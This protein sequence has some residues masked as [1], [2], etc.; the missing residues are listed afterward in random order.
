MGG[1][2]SKAVN[3][4]KTTIDAA[5]NTTLSSTVNA[6][7]N[8]TCSNIQRVEGVECCVINFGDQTCEATAINEVVSSGR[9]DSTVTQGIAQQIAQSAQASVEGLLLGYAESEV[10]NRVKNYVDIAVNTTQTFET[11]CSKNATGLN[12]QTVID[13]YCGCGAE[14]PENRG[15]DVNFGIQS[16]TL[17]AMGSCVSDVV[18]SSQAAQDYSALIG[19]TAEASVSGVSLLELFLAI[20]GP[21]LI[22]IIAP[23]GFKILTAPQKQNPTPAQALQQ[24]GARVRNTAF[25]F[26]LFALI[27]WYPGIVAWQLGAPPFQSNRTPI[28]D[29][30]AC[31]PDGTARE[32]FTINR[33]QWFDPDCVSKPA[34]S[35]CSEDDQYKSYT[36]CGVFGKANLC[37]DTEFETDRNLFDQMLAACSK[38]TN[39]YQNRVPFGDVPTIASR[40]LREEDKWPSSCRICF[41][42]EEGVK[43]VN[44]L[45]VQMDPV[46]LGSEDFPECKYDQPNPP[47]SC[48]LPCTGVD[49]KAYMAAGTDANGDP[50]LCE[51]T[52]SEHCY[53]SEAAYLNVSPSECLLPAYQQGKK[54]ISKK[55][56]EVEAAEDIYR[57]KFATPE[58]PLLGKLRIGDMCSL[59]PF[60]WLNCNGDFS[61]NYETQLPESD[62]NFV[63]ADRACRN[64]FTDCQDAQFLADKAGQDAVDDKCADD[65]QTQKERDEFL[66]SIPMWSGVAYFIFFLISVGAS[67]WGSRKAAEV[68]QQPGGGELMPEPIKKLSYATRAHVVAGS[69][70]T[71][72]YVLPGILLLGLIAGVLG[73]VLIE[74]SALTI[75]ITAGCGVLLLVSLAYGVYAR[76]VARENEK[77]VRAFQGDQQ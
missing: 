71:F 28:V 67:L 34:G 58:E 74:P 3:N 63:F 5:V 61:C 42:N 6:S 54:K 55:L 1:G 66:D 16:I 64:D 44:G 50:I 76:R 18:G 53:E 2:S 37:D 73:I 39:L 36:T 22:F 4:I 33:F 30:Q 46:K 13:T 27:V 7:A 59:Q 51:S 52:E 14:A 8:A 31:R 12:D 45:Y 9:L 75:G 11:D 49:P 69:S 57:Q 35:G 62:P 25:Y 48:Y 43:E 72:K 21:M 56:R 26:L 68:A 70:S 38:I 15:V 10:S 17:E 29:N 65:V 32:D 60:E 77:A 40:T 19:Q 47:A 20:I 24:S 41:S 23:V